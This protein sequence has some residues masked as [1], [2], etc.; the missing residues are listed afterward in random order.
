MSKESFQK[1]Y[2]ELED[3][4]KKIA[5]K[6]YDVSGIKKQVD[7]AMRLY[8]QGSYDE[9]E[10]ILDKAR[11]TLDRAGKRPLGV[12]ILSILFFI[13]FLLSLFGILLGLLSGLLL[14]GTPV[15]SPPSI[16]PE[17]ETVV[18]NIR[19]QINSMIL[20]AIATAMIS[21][22]FS[23]VFGWGLWKLK[24]GVWILLVFLGSLGIF[25]A[26]ISLNVINFIINVIIV[27]YLLQPH[28]KLA[29]KVSKNLGGIF[30]K[31]TIACFVLGILLLGYFAIFTPCEFGKT[32]AE[33]HECYTNLAIE[34]RDPS[35][36]Q[37]I[38][39]NLSRDECINKVAVSTY[40][41][42]LCEMI[43][44]NLSRDECINKVAVSTYDSSLCEMIGDN[45]K[46]KNCYKDIAIKTSNRSLCEKL[47]DELSIRDCERSILS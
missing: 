29:F 9:G 21:A 30:L 24:R 1:K 11:E 46:K 20:N 8:K 13:G 41:S 25:G 38:K 17:E 37:R 45:W 34:K 12:T 3:L 47:E 43:G 14:F 6:G 10:I 19:E 40:D 7:E 39:M 15:P 36:C 35:I 33:M 32:K 31:F 28:V 26:V 2:R 42:S 5:S 18:I 23:L 27:G 16:T 44:D 4:Y 22:V